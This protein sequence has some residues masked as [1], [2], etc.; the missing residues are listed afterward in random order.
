VNISE[1]VTNFLQKNKINYILNQEQDL[2]NFSV[3][4]PSPTEDRCIKIDVY[5]CG[6]NLHFPIDNIWCF[7]DHYC[8][9]EDYLTF[10]EVNE[11]LTFIHQI[12]HEELIG[13][14]VQYAGSTYQLFCSPLEVNIQI[15][16][17]M[18]FL[19]DN[20]LINKEYKFYIS[21]FKGTY[22]QYIQGR[23]ESNDQKN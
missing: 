10:N 9:T 16:K 22:D 14:S 13:F 18:M 21:S 17:K 7:C 4:I 5:D 3:Q 11:L 20:D 19:K 12:I 2:Q 1:L 6:Y 23:M 8:S 15:E